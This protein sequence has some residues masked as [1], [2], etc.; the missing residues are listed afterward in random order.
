MQAAGNMIAQ[1]IA[2]RLLYCQV[3]NVVPQIDA[4]LLVPN[5][6]AGVAVG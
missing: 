3:A 4:L 6:V 1:L 2:T 5:K